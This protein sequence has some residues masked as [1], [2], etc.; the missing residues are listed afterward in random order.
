MPYFTLREARGSLFS[1][2][3]GQILINNKG[4]GLF[5]VK[6]RQEALFF[7][8]EG[9]VILINNKG[10]GLFHIKGRREARGKP[11]GTWEAHPFVPTLLGIVMTY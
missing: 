7:S 5:H 9:G 6:G 3:G 1:L 4:G 8:L 2:E 10:G 11:Y